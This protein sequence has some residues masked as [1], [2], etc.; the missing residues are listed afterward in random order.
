MSLSKV[1]FGSGGRDEWIFKAETGTDSF[2]TNTPFYPQAVA[3]DKY[4][5]Y[6]GFAHNGDFG[7]TADVYYLAAVNMQGGL[8]FEKVLGDVGDTNDLT[9]TQNDCCM[10]ISPYD[11][12]NV[13]V[14]FTMLAETDWFIANIGIDGAVD[15]M[16]EMGYASSTYNRPYLIAAASNG[17]VYAVNGLTA[18]DGRTLLLDRS[19]GT[20]YAATVWKWELADFELMRSVKIDPSNDSLVLLGRSLATDYGAHIKTLSVAGTVTY[21]NQIYQFND[22]GDDTYPEGLAVDSSGNIY[23]GWYNVDSSAAQTYSY[24]TKLSQNH[25][26][27]WTMRYAG[28]RKGIIVLSPDESEVYRYANATGGGTITAFR[29]SDGTELWKSDVSSTSNAMQGMFLTCNSDSVFMVGADV[30]AASDKA[31]ILKLL[32]SSLETGGTF[33][34]VTITPGVATD[35][36]SVTPTLASGSTS[37]TSVTATPVD[38]SSAAELVA[39]DTPNTI[40]LKEV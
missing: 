31:I 1:F 28:Y 36:S 29:A 12:D 18:N 19:N 8:V 16:V 27:Q 6:L 15:H 30:N 4:I 40:S 21:A 26:H 37:R 33:D 20:P 9:S 25:T 34:V 32:P 3:S 24:I 11:T 17:D 38:A 23:I 39:L 35:Y 7:R 13:I 10:V 14:S 22:T 5:W 2:Q